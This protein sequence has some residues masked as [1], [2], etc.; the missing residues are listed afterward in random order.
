[1]SKKQRLLNAVKTLNLTI[2]QR[3]ELVEAIEDLGGG[4][5]VSTIEFIEDAE[6]AIGMGIKINNYKLSIYSHNEDDASISINDLDYKKLNDLLKGT[7]K[8]I[9]TQSSNISKFDVITFS[10]EF[11]STNDICLGSAVTGE[12][13]PVLRTHYSDPYNYLYIYL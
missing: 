6:S 11:D 1:M 5:K 3:Q 7:T 9:I 12:F 8:L 13:V 4:E 2:E 10:A